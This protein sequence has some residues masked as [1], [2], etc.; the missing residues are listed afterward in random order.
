MNREEYYFAENEIREASERNR[1]AVKRKKKAGTLKTVAVVMAFAVVFGGV[2]G[3]VSAGIQ[4]LRN[5]EQLVFTSEL[6]P[7]DRLSGNSTEKRS[8]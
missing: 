6:A 8:S 4:A 5:S 1:R 2:R 3:G 7:G